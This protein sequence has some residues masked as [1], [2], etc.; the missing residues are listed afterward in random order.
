[1][2]DRRREIRSCRSAISDSRRCSNTSWTAARSALTSRSV[3]CGPALT[4]TIRPA[5]SGF[6]TSERVRERTAAFALTSSRSVAERLSANVRAMRSDVEVADSRGCE[7]LGDVAGQ[8][9]FT[10]ITQITAPLRGPTAVGSGGHLGEQKR[11]PADRERPPDHAACPPTLPR[12]STTLRPEH[13]AARPPLAGPA[14]PPRPARCPRWRHLADTA[15]PLASATQPDTPRSRLGRAV[16]L[17]VIARREDVARPRRRCPIWPRCAPAT[18]VPSP[19]PEPSTWTISSP[20]PSSC[21]NATQ[22]S[23]TRCNSATGGCR[24]MNTR[25]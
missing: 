13:A 17:G 8:P 2:R 16:L 4:T 1:M 18:T 14:R 5:A 20:A 12:P 21:S 10:K 11:R 23:A 15:T 9:A 25:T 7:K 3:A 6:R 22:A 19:R 24:W